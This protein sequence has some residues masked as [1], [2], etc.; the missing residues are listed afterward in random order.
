[1]CYWWGK[2]EMKDGEKILLEGYKQLVEIPLNYGQ[3]NL[4]KA[5]EKMNR[6]ISDTLLEYYDIKETT[7]CQQTSNTTK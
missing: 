3:G 2:D 1:M 7:K 5:V 4:L 6:I